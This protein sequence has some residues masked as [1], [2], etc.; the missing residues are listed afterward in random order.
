MKELSFIIDS[1]FSY[2]N[3]YVNFIG[4]QI[5]VYN[6]IKADKIAEILARSKQHLDKSQED[7]V[8]WEM[9][10]FV[11]KEGKVIASGIEG[12]IKNPPTVDVNRRSWII[13]S[14][15]EPWRLHICK[16]DIEITALNEHRKI[17][18][19]GMGI[20][21]TKGKFLGT[22][23]SGIDIK[24]FQK[25]LNYILD[26]ENYSYIV[27]DDKL[28]YILYSGEDNKISN[29]DKIKVAYTLKYL[30][31]AP[32]S[33]G[34]LNETIFLDNTEY[35][36][37]T[38]TMNY[39][40]IVII[41]INKRNIMDLKDLEMQIVKLEKQGRYD[42]MFLLS[43]LY[44]FQT[45]VINPIVGEKTHYSRFHIPK[46]FSSH[47]NDLFLSLEQMDSFMELKIQKEVAE[48]LKEK[49]GDL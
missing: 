34:T 5:A 47:I 13:K 17:I 19:F 12:V 40:F 42:K 23:S 29:A 44:L 36:F 24:R 25:R 32:H 28:R 9:I 38:K 16:P 11:T 21:N 26:N 18:P 31:D 22:I 37:Y 15:Q 49:E 3:N 30:K 6:D 33:F 35:I 27:L 20:T 7:I 41:G 8:Q 43:L 4:N 10:D 1:V 45:K 39:P 48:A 46:V 14:P 2:I